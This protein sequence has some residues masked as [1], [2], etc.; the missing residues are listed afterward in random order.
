MAINL[1]AAR[2]LCTA[3]EL[4]LVAAATGERLAALSAARL[5]GK[6]ARAR[7]GAPF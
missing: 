6:I 7:A 4:E 5:Q 1:R 3:R 2:A